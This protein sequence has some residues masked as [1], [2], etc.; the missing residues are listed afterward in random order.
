MLMTVNARRRNRCG[1]TSG[2]GRTTMRIGNSDRGREADAQ[3]HEARRVAPPGLLP[4]HDAEREAADRERDD[5]RARASRA[6]AARSGRVTPG[7]GATR[8]RGPAG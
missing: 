1:G 8:R 6:G 3:G 2:S 5:D 4:A 7:H